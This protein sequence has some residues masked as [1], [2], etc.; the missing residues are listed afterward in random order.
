[1]CD[2]ILFT[3]THVS[4]FSVQLEGIMFDSDMSFKSHGEVLKFHPQK[5]V[6]TL[7]LALLPTVSAVSSGYTANDANL[8]DSAKGV[9]Q[10][11]MKPPAHQGYLGERVTNPPYHCQLMLAPG[12]WAVGMLMQLASFLPPKPTEDKIKSSIFTST[13]H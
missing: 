13:K 4:P 10:L 2:S 8:V 3:I 12:E 5:Y 9:W 6:G 1:M 11:K 7:P